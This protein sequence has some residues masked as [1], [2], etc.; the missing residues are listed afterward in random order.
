[1]ILIADCW[2]AAPVQCSRTLACVSSN[3]LLMGGKSHAQSQPVALGPS[4]HTRDGTGHLVRSFYQHQARKTGQK[5]Q[6]WAGR[7]SCYEN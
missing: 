7:R 2:V 5:C 3:E 1:M 6:D 4:D